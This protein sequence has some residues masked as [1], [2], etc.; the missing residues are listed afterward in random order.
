M[1]PL[2]LKMQAFGSFAEETVINFADFHGTFLITGDTGAG[3]TTLFDAICFALFGEASGD[4]RNG[5]RSSASLRS[6][7]ADPASK[8]FVELEFSY[9]GQ[10]YRVKR[11]PDYERAKKRGE[12]TTKEPANAEIELPDGRCIGGVGIS[13]R[14]PQ[15]DA[16]LAERL[17]QKLMGKG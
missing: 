17:A 15:E 4:S 14:K 12:G 13:G 3:K 5:A 9:R 16:E 10:T 11:N 7:F 6:D 2:Q 1:K 8:T